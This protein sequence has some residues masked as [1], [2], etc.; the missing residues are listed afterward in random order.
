MISQDTRVPGLL[1]TQRRPAPPPSG[2]FLRTSDRRSDSAP[3]VLPGSPRASSPT[4]GARASNAVPLT[5][6]TRAGEI[7]APLPTHAPRGIM[8]VPSRR[9]FQ[10]G[11][12]PL[13]PPGHVVVVG[14]RSG[15]ANT[16]TPSSRLKIDSAFP[17][18]NGGLSIL[19]S[20]KEESTRLATLSPFH[21]RY[22]GRTPSPV[23]PLLPSIKA[24]FVKSS[25]GSAGPHSSSRTPLHVRRAP[26]SLVEQEKSG[27]SPLARRADQ[28]DSLPVLFGRNS[29]RVKQ[30]GLRDP[31]PL[32]SWTAIIGRSKR[33][34]W[35]FLPTGN[36]DTEPVYVEPDSPR[37]P[38]AQCSPRRTLPRTHRNG[39][40]R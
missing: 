17:S 20:I 11:C 33:T 31:C 30:N 38:G 32:C 29:A 21:T 5:L 1:S 22:T 4:S 13:S 15:K 14:L 6:G 34:F 28:P 16:E 27:L 18:N 24:L 35:H 8:R 2:A 7:N 26:S 25:T 23:D 37:A 40:H 36:G 10:R 19:F 9:S 39:G 12:P 3:P